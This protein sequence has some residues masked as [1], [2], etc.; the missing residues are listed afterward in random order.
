LT[1]F[2][3]YQTA[4]FFNPSG[5]PKFAD[6]GLSVF[7]GHPQI[8]LRP[9]AEH[10]PQIGAD[11]L[12]GANGVIVLTPQVTK[13][14]VAAAD[15]LLAI[16]RFGVGYDNV[17]VAACTAADV[18]LLITAGAVDRPVAEATVGWMIALTHHMK[19]KDLLVCEGKWD[20]RSGYMGRELRDRTL[21]VVGLG[22]IARKLLEL[23]ANWGMNQPVAFDPFVD[24]L[25][26]ANLGV[27]LVE[28]DAL[29]R[30]SD[31]VS[32]HCPLTDKTRGLIGRRELGL[33]KP[34]AYLINTA[35]GGIVDEDALYEA[36][37]QDRIAGA[38][39][40]CFAT[41]PLTA[42]NRFGEFENVI[43][44]PHSIA[45]TNEMFRDIGRAAC[46][47]MVDLSLKRTPR[48]IVNPEVLQ[49]PGFQRKWDRLCGSV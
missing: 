48:G 16:G 11:Q 44:A 39:L 8:Q 2:H 28:L 18:L 31:F 33:M 47:G 19:V 30:T 26:A 1:H 34:E 32:I 23:L 5:E 6:L 20:E 22:G 35:R 4:D 27:R 15:E 14:T 49:S 46:Q 21:G 3:V 9:F 10:R 29:M 42:P 37:E 12:A 41:E 40:D 45:W 36:L 43:L 25:A 13:E 17:D 38:A 7:E 24:P